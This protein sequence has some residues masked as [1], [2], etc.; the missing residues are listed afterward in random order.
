MR[1]TVLFA[2]SVAALVFLSGCATKPQ[3]PVNFA[4]AALAS[5]NERVG[6]AMTAM[7]KVQVHLPG[8]GCLLC[9]LAATAMNSDL[10]KHADTLTLEDLPKLKESIAASL[11]KRGTAVVVIPDALDTQEL[12][13]ADGAGDNVAD[14]NFAPL[15]KKYGIDKLLVIE[16]NAIGFERHYSSYIPTGDPKAFVRGRGY[17]VN[18]A[19]NTY[20]WYLP[21]NIVKSADGKWDEPAKF[22]GLTNAY[23]QAIELGKDHLLKPLGN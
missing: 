2:L 20:E 21:M 18:L 16:L 23:Y 5:G 9:I 12:S 22:P 15:Q 19:S 4:P 10:S 14:K 11:R 17:M 1:P 8:A 7:P 13:K 3:L 6:I